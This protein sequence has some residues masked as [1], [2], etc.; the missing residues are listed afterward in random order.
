M[1][2]YNI[3]STSC[4]VVSLLR[5]DINKGNCSQQIKQKMWRWFSIPVHHRKWNISSCCRFLYTKLINFI[6]L[7]LFI[8]LLIK[9]LAILFWKMKNQIFKKLYNRVSVFIIDFVCSVNIFHGILLSLKLEFIVQHKLWNCWTFPK[10][11]VYLSK[12]GKQKNGPK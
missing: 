10:M 9:L 6:K 4:R 8:F 7:K 11:H 2:L 5:F 12:R 1:A 3:F